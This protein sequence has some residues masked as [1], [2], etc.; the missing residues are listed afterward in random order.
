[1]L[2]AS[3]TPCHVVI[4]VSKSNQL[5]FLH[6]FCVITLKSGKFPILPIQPLY[7]V[8]R[9][10]SNLIWQF[11]ITMITTS[12]EPVNIANSLVCPVNK[13]ITWIMTR[14]S[15][16]DRLWSMNLGPILNRLGGVLRRLYS[17]WKSSVWICKSKKWCCYRNVDKIWRL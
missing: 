12:A 3:I 2:M 8:I 13:L 11:F 15:A 6:H 5:W 17:S 4:F 1:M 16:R 9:N 7:A 10:L 14:W